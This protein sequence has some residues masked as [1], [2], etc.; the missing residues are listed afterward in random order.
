MMISPAR[1][2]RPERRRIANISGKAEVPSALPAKGFICSQ[3]PHT[4]APVTIRPGASRLLAIFYL[5]FSI[6]QD[7]LVRPVIQDPAGPSPGL[8]KPF[9]AFSS[10]LKVIFFAPHHYAPRP[11]PRPM[12]PHDLL[13]C[14]SP[15]QFKVRP[16]RIQGYSR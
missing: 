10:L 16:G 1:R 14:A 12:A 6:Q 8:L 11:I 9:Q 13:V 3:P 5:L 7:Q 15:H 4:V 2:P